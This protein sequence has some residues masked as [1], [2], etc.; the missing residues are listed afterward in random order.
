MKILLAGFGTRG[1]VQ[2][3]V[4]LGLGLRAAGHDVTVGAS[5]GFAE[6]VCGYGLAFA[7]IGGDIEGWVRT[8]GDALVRR[9]IRVFPA[10]LRYLRADVARSLDETL[11]AARGADLILSGV[12][13][14]APTVAEALGI[15]HR[16]LIYCPQLLRSRHHPP[17]GCPRLDLPHALN[18][19]LWR[20]GD[21]LCNSLFRPAID[22][23]R[24]QHGLA[25]AGNLVEQWIGDDP[26][27]ACDA[28]LATLPPDAPPQAVQTGSLA[29]LDRAPLDA[30]LERFLD[31]GPPPVIVGFGSMSDGDPHRTTAGIVAALERTA[32]RGILVAGWAGLGGHPLPASVIRVSSVP[33][34]ALLP[35]V[36]LAVHHGGAG[37][38][39]A[40]ARAGV[41]QVI[42]PHFA[43][44]LY[45][46]HQVWKRGLGSRPI[47][48]TALDETTLARAIEFV[49][50]RP[51]IAAR[52]RGVSAKIAATDGLAAVVAQ[53]TRTAGD[54]PRRRA[55]QDAPRT[56]ATAAAPAA[57]RACPTE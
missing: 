10:A 6:W 15:P 16:T 37:T 47:A 45:W 44:Q 8:H 27:V 1:D 49:A 13:G 11:E 21:P 24:R 42:V 50:G 39:A 20:L 9:P 54:Q 23:W 22:A 35:R 55:A 34:G 3:L 43:D 31:A 53:V 12:H 57:R 2:P 14:A 26:I 30:A 51:E 7:A 40:A 17:M 33:H 41:P 4:A 28:A 52:A 19:L 25:P 48:R 36:A 5:S 18:A 56:T 46:A 29:L 32:R 38:T